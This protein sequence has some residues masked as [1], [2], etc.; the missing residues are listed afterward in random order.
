MLEWRKFCRDKRTS[1][2]AIISNVSKL[3][4][5]MWNIM[6]RTYAFAMHVLHALSLHFAHS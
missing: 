1:S 6:D 5:I 4:I 2:T 3:S